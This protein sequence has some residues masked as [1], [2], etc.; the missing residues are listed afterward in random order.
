MRPWLGGVGCFV[1]TVNLILDSW[2]VLK[3]SS[4]EIVPKGTISSKHFYAIQHER[5]FLQKF[6]GLQIYFVPFYVHP[7]MAFIALCCMIVTRNCFVTNFVWNLI[8]IVNFWKSRL[9]VYS[10]VE[11]E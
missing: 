2:F 9:A 6:I 7:N 3:S 8:N 11:K 1:R 5:A 4:L 10:M